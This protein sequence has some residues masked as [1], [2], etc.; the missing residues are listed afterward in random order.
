MRGHSELVIEQFNGLWARGDADSTPPDHF[1]ECNNIQFIQGGFETRNGLDKYLSGN[2]GLNSIVRMYTFVQ[3]TG[4]S[5]L[6]L[7]IY[8]NI[9]DVQGTTVL[10]PI[11]TIA[12]MTDFAF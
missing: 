8:G 3:E 9:Y 1:S 7:D 12:G 5:L 2:F 11:L 10:G 6:V 4:E